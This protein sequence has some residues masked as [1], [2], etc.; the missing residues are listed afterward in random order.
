MKD[1][2]IAKVAA[3]TSDFY[4]AAAQAANVASVRQQWEKVNK[5]TLT[6]VLMF[7]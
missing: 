7:L 4:S 5:K 2:V 1:S 3:Q 6:K